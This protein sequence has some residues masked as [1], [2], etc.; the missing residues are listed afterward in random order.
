MPID[1]WEFL[2]ATPEEAN[3]IESTENLYV[4][5]EELASELLSIVTIPT[6]KSGRLHFDTEKTTQRKDR[7]AAVILG[8]YMAR[9]IR[10][11]MWEED[12]PV[13]LA[14]GFAQNSI[15]NK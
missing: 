15:L 14:T 10:D 12:E 5:I 1:K 6:P 4:E 8:N 11:E 3:Y 2:P 13:K 9:K 7:W